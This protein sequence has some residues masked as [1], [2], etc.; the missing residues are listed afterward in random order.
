MERTVAFYFDGGSGV[1]LGH[2]MR[3]AALGE[4]FRDQGHR[5]LAVGPFDPAAQI[6]TGEVFEWRQRGNGDT[7]E[8]LSESGGAIDEAPDRWAEWL[9]RQGAPLLVID[10]YRIRPE[11]VGALRSAGLFVVYLDD[12]NA[13]PM[14]A[15]LVINAGLAAERENYRFQEAGRALLG[16]AYTLLRQRVLEAKERREQRLRRE[17]PQSGGAARMLVTLGGGDP[18]GHLPRLLEAVERTQQSGRS[19]EAHVI[20]GPYMGFPERYSQA[21]WLRRY[22]PP[23]DIIGLLPEMDLAVTA[24]G[25]TLQEFLAVGIPSAVVVQAGNQ[26][27]AALEAC[28]REAAIPLFHPAPAPTR[29]AVPEPLATETIAQRLAQLLDKPER[30]RRYGERGN[31]LIDGHGAR[32]CY[33]EI[34]KEMHN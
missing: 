34:L 27:P 25:V 3:C 1:G 14:T 33:E 4:A 26:V 19:L 22:D 8:A 16:P 21:P 30:T 5:V 20:V 18:M 2:V 31:R 32:R 12:H 6:L 28:R 29:D 24:A 7:V 23:T 11:T 17:R 9:K 10:S 15:H 13:F